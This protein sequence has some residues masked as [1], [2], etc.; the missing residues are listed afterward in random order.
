MIAERLAEARHAL[1]RLAQTHAAPPGDAGSAEGM[2]F[3]SGLLDYLWE[4]EQ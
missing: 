4:R 1:A 2:S 3:L